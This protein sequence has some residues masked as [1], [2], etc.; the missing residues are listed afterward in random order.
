MQPVTHSAALLLC[1]EMADSRA[2]CGAVYIYKLAAGEEQEEVLF[3]E[4]LPGAP[5]G[6]HVRHASHLLA[7]CSPSRSQLL[8]RLLVA[9]KQRGLCGCWQVGIAQSAA[10]DLTALA[11]PALQSDASWSVYLAAWTGDAAQAVRGCW[12]GCPP[13]LADPS[14]YSAPHV[15]CL[16]SCIAPNMLTAAMV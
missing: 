5:I 4:G 14:P 9:P 1:R 16:P 2:T 12:A 6:A 11:F 7:T 15:P 13:P 8:S 3:I 10:L